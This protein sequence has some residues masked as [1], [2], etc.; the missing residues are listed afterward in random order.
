MNSFYAATYGDLYAWVSDETAARSARPRRCE[1]TPAGAA[2]HP[3]ACV[4]PWSRA[5]ATCLRLDDDGATIVLRYRG[6]DLC[7]MFSLGDGGWQ[8]ELTDACDPPTSPVLRRLRPF[9]ACS[10]F[11]Y[12][13]S[14]QSEFRLWAEWDDPTFDPNDPLR[15]LLFGYRDEGRPPF[16]W[17]LRFG[18]YLPD[19][20]H[21]L[22]RAWVESRD[23]SAMHT[24]A[25]AFPR[26]A[27]SLVHSTM[28]LVRF[29]PY[30]DIALALKQ[31]HIVAAIPELSSLKPDRFAHYHSYRL[32]RTA[33]AASIWRFDSKGR[34]LAPPSVPSATF[35]PGDSLP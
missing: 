10:L 23:W 33:P 13:A 17:S 21:A 26:R 14:A 18:R 12:R 27:R 24:L 9:V 7:R 1:G 20:K 25:R 6:A 34:P 31:R 35:A 2:A 15:E 3:G 8:A 5:A 28:Q 29:D 11:R 22:S 30:A 32:C 4:F 16:A 19:G